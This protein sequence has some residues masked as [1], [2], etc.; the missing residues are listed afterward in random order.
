MVA[1]G[2][3]IL[4]VEPDCVV[5]LNSSPDLAQVRLPTKT[6]PTPPRYAAECSPPTAR[7]ATRPSSAATR[8]TPTAVATLLPVCS[9]VFNLDVNG[10]GQ[11]TEADLLIVVSAMGMQ[12]P[13]PPG[14][15][16]NGDGVVDVIDLVLV[17]LAI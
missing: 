12:P 16:L 5:V 17:A 2:L 3:G 4:R 7:S 10:D 11:V 13:G 9:S 8:S 1:V 15:D 6:T 14:A